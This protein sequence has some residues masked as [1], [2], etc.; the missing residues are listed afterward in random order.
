MGPKKR[1]ETIRLIELI[2]KHP[3][4]VKSIGVDVSIKKK[5][6]KHNEKLG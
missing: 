1:Q 3:S 4:F 6:G 2:R 5:E